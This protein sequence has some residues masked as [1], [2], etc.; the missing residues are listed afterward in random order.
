MIFCASSSSLNNCTRAEQDTTEN[1]WAGPALGKSVFISSNGIDVNGISGEIT[2]TTPLGF[3]QIDTI[4]SDGEETAVISNITMEK[5]KYDLAKDS[6][7]CPNYRAKIKQPDRTFKVQDC[8]I[9]SHGKER[10]VCPNTIEINAAGESQDES[11]KYPTKLFTFLEKKKWKKSI[12]RCLKHPEEASAIE[13]H[14]RIVPLTL[15][16]VMKAPVHVIETLLIAYPN[17]IKARDD[18]KM[19]PLHF[20]F[21]LGSSEEIANILVHSYPEA[22]TIKDCKGHSPRDILRAYHRYYTN[23]R[24]NGR[25]RDINK[26]NVD[27]NRKRLINAFLDMRVT[28]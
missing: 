16:I 22:L 27:E 25:E 10:K 7:S 5:E 21:R 4:T 28:F 13:D 19:L 15:A 3:Y 23:E 26:T 2:K 1:L 9:L 12:R 24:I 11:L 17:G 8:S 20:A 6:I 18:K 14:W